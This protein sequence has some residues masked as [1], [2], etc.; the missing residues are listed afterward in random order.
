MPEIKYNT[1]LNIREYSQYPQKPPPT[2]IP[3]SQVGS[4]KNRIL[5]V[6]TKHSGRVLLQKGKYNDTKNLFQ[7][8]RT[9]DLDELL[10][11]TR[12]GSD[13][14]V[15]LLNKEYYWKSGEGSDRFLKFVHHLATIYGKFTGRY[16]QLNGFTLKELGLPPLMEMSADN[17]ET[18]SGPATASNGA[19]ADIVLQKRRSA[20]KQLEAP[21]ST[22][23][24]RSAEF[25]LHYANMD[26]TANGKLP[27]KPML[28]MDVDRPGFKLSFQ[29]ELV[30]TTAAPSPSSNQIT[31]AVNRKANSRSELSLASLENQFESQNDSH[32]FLFSPDEAKQQR[33]L[34]PTIAEN[35]QATGITLPLR[36]YKPDMKSEETSK[37]FVPLKSAAAY[38]EQLKSESERN[39]TNG[40]LNF[41]H[42]FTTRALDADFGIEEADIS[43]E[44][45]ENSYQIQMRKAVSRGK[46]VVPDT[47]QYDQHSIS[48]EILEQ[49]TNN[50]SN[51]AIDSSIREIENFMDS[52]FGGNSAYSGTSP[53]HEKFDDLKSESSYDEDSNLNSV[54][55]DT[56]L[57]THA[58]EPETRTGLKIEKDAEV[59]EMLDEIGWSITDTSD[60][61]VKKLNK[62]LNQ[63]KHKNIHELRFLD[64]GKDTL[65]NEVS[66]AAS[67]VDNLVEVFKKM[68]VSLHMIA[69]QID[70]IESNSKGLQVRAVNKKILFNN[71]SEILNKVRVSP[72][73]LNMI[74]NYDSFLDVQTVEDLEDNLL[75]LYDAMGTIGSATDDDLSNMKALKQ[76]QDA[77][78]A[79]SATFI[80][81][82]IKFI[83]DEFKLTV[84][85]LNEEV[86]TLYPRNL[87]SHIKNY[88]AYN[89]IMKFIKCVS[90]KDLKLINDKLNSY[91]SNFLETLLNARLKSVSH[92]STNVTSSR[93]SQRIDSL[94]SLLKAKS[95]RFGSTRLVSKLAGLSED[96]RGN[97]RSQLTTSLPD[98]VSKHGEEISD[99]KIILR[100]VQ[101]TNELI[102]VIQYFFGNFFHSTSI[103]E[104]S[105]YVKTTPF[106]SRIRELDDPD[107]DL[108]NYKSNANDLLQSMTSIFGNYINKFIKKLTPSELIIPQLLLELYRL[109]NDANSKNQDFINFSFLSKV[110]ERYRGIWNKFIAGQVDLLNKSDI[111]SKAGILPVIRNLNQIFLTTE[112]SLQQSANYRDAGDV[113][114]EVEH[115]INESYLR[116]TKAAVDLFERDDP[117]LK[118][119]SHDDRERAHRNI[120]ILQN[121][122]AVLLELDELNS[123]KTAPVKYEL[124]KVFKDVQRECFDYLLHRNLGKMIEFVNG[125]S[126]TNHS[127]RKKDDKILIRSLASTH[128]AKDVRPKVVELRHKMEKY[129]VVSNNVEE[130]DLLKKL[131][132]DMETDY[133][134]IFLKFDKIVKASDHD[135]DLYASP[136]E[137]RR[138]FDNVHSTR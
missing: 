48:L 21:S 88:L 119:N 56:R 14:F 84:G 69:P 118:S 50:E 22:P 95:N 60:A 43:E 116:L 5:I 126:G 46:K 130:L 65:A 11:I 85:E 86:E 112:T 49:S 67:E 34:M 24:S 64:F 2:D 37:S 96:Q 78:A 73:A 123:S 124:T 55:L 74:V 59:E 109:I 71:L 58:T 31:G 110:V 120:T 47:S 137:V 42:A 35:A 94:T 10:G 89:G 102:Y 77:Y 132:I 76:F 90:E 133:V 135:V 9:W 79:T 23:S 57:N 134:N 44:E 45:T 62:E 111:R 104:Y 97:N 8:G 113:L 127:K 29:R 100:M 105:D 12:V 61:F 125:F 27:Q 117:L 115:L 63:I 4:V 28:V 70:D 18:A 98:N 101:E 33:K 136:S 13:A 20:L 51:S 122:F 81:H 128:T 131:W 68:E 19:S 114:L 121:V 17:S 80:Q 138:M 82:F 41:Q 53:Q 3:P 15:L 7:I 108:I 36:K 106:L 72:K 83:R 87:L 6:C 26:F 93:L 16:P 40:S 52:E 129:V 38:G 32:S 1:H 99:P 39:K 103:L 92:D 75:I 107:L 30:A 25:A 91:L 54:Q 66:V